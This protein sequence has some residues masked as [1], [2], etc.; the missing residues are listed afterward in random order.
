MTVSLINFS[1]ADESFKDLKHKKVSYLD[2]FLLKLDNQLIKRSQYLR[3]QLITTRVQY[4]YVSTQIEHDSK[5][6]KIFVNI[7]TVMDKRR[8]TKK[9]YQQ[10]LSDCNQVRNLIFYR[11]HGYT[12]FRQKRN[13]RLSK[14][15][16]EE[17]FKEVFFYNLSFSEKEIEFLMDNMFVNVTII[18][19]VNKTELFCAGKIND[20]ELE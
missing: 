14:H 2:F 17:T 11:K 10:K 8:Y 1:Y 19:P 15:I 6:N 3:A 9:K 5:E 16:M 7:Y 13:P 20:Y 12:F 4:S 18:N